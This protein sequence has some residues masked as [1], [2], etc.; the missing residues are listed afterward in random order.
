MRLLAMIFVRIVSTLMALGL[1][2]VSVLA[3]IEIPAGWFGETTVF[4]PD[5]IV[6]QLQEARWDD[7]SVVS[8][9][10]VLVL[11]GVLSIILGALSRP[12]LTV[13]S[14]AGPDCQLERPALEKSLTRDVSEIDGVDDVSVKVTRNR[15]GVDVTTR[16]HLDSSSVADRVR[17]QLTQRCASYGLKQKVSIDVQAPKEQTA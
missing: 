10:V 9:S 8:A 2:A 17:T 4:L 7:R 11:I 16:R 15:M 1:F 14:H 6:T 3:L 5:N 12:T 13:L